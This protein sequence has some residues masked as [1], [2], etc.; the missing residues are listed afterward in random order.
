LLRPNRRKVTSKQDYLKLEHKI[1]VQK[2]FKCKYTKT[3]IQSPE[4]CRYLWRTKRNNSHPK[5]ELTSKGTLILNE[6]LP[7]SEHKMRLL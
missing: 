5:K 1:Y 3:K 6:N 2:E 7:W 4:K